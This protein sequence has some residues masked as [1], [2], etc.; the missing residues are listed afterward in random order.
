M[1]VT[2][3]EVHEIALAYYDWIAYPLNHY[4]E[5]REPYDL[6]RPHGRRPDWPRREREARAAGDHRPIHR[7]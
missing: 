7:Q 1:R 6:H 5:P 2:Q 3:I 4:Y